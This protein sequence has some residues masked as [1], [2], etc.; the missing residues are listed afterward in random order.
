MAKQEELTLE[1][2]GEMMDEFLK[3][4][5]I[6]MLITLPEGT[7]EPQIQDNVGF[8]SVAHFYILLQAMGSVFGSLR[9][10]LDPSQVEQFIDTLL[11]LLKKDVLDKGGEK[12]ADTAD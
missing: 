1:K 7:V 5:E 11:D 6:K 2:F 9:D 3:N 12:D 10:L 8:G 4:N